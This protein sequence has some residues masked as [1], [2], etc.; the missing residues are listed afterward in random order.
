MQWGRATVVARLAYRPRNWT[1]VA[2]TYARQR[3]ALRLAI[4]FDSHLVWLAAEY[5]ELA[6][7]KQTSAIQGCTTL[8]LRQGS[9]IVMLNC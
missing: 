7:R 4:G 3:T 5:G 8:E 6:I 9:D 2:Q 1:H